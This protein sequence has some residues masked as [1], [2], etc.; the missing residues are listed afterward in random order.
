MVQI[1]NLQRYVYSRSGNRC[2][3]FDLTNE[4]R[5]QFPYGLSIEPEHRGLLD[6]FLARYLQ[7]D[8]AVFDPEEIEALEGLAFEIKV[9]EDESGRTWTEP[10]C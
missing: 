10:V 4:W 7:L 3:G 8:P 2:V 9:C 6:Q 1:K 5:E